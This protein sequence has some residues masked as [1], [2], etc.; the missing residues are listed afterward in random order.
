[1]IVGFPVKCT[2]LSRGLLVVDF[3][4]WEATEHYDPAN[5]S[6]FGSAIGQEA[7]PGYRQP[8]TSAFDS[9]QP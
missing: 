4:S 8:A 1:M 9:L 3:R 6:D 5:D 2:G 7:E